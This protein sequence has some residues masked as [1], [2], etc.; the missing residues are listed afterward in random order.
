[1]FFHQLGECSYMS[2]SSNAVSTESLSVQETAEPSYS[3][4]PNLISTQ[5]SRKSWECLF[6]PSRSMASYGQESECSLDPDSP[7]ISEVGCSLALAG[8][9]NNVSQAECSFAPA[10]AK[11][12]VRDVKDREEDEDEEEEMEESAKNEG[13]LFKEVWFF[14]KQACV[15]CVSSDT[16][17][18]I[19]KKNG[20]Q[21]VN[22]NTNTP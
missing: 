6:T 1:M 20:Q 2:S 7:L 14:F 4:H 5:L 11:Q 12:M 3:S 8:L 10:F 13:I 19:L 18:F 15:I 17:C 21:Y 22:T 16:S 9:R